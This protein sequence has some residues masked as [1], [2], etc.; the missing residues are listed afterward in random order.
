MT[1]IR[2]LLVPSEGP[3]LLEGTCGIGVVARLMSLG[4]LSLHSPRRSASDPML[5]NR[6]YCLIIVIKR[7]T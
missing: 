1:I 2:G 4:K 5:L 6:R 3:A 7:M